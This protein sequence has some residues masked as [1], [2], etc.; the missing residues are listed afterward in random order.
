MGLFTNY[1]KTCQ[2]ILTACDQGYTNCTDELKHVLH[3][4]PGILIEY[5]CYESAIILAKYHAFNY[6]KF[7]KKYV[8]QLIK[9]LRNILKNDL[10]KGLDMDD[11]TFSSNL[12]SAIFAYM[13]EFAENMNADELLDTS[14]VSTT[15]L[16]LNR[17]GTED[18]LDPVYDVIRSFTNARYIYS[19]IK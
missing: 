8:D 6:R 19:K 17:T 11:R 18:R 3:S 9:Y 10:G 1:D 2:R 4:N 13:K 15:L 14:M 16:F 12:G 7:I 5:F